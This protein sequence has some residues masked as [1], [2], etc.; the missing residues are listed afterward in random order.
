MK[1]TRV[2]PIFLDKFLLVEIETDE[3]IIGLDDPQELG[4]QYRQIKSK[5]PWLNVFGSCC[6]SDLRHVTE[7]AKVVAK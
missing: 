5:M 2:E 7:I 4:S 3:G 6:G 1:I